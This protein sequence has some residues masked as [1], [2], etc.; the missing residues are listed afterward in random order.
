MR[1]YKSACEFD[2][3]RVQDDY[4]VIGSEFCNFLSTLLTFRLI[5]AFDKAGL[6]EEYTYRK[7][8][9]VLIRAKKARVGSENWQL[10]RRNP[11]HLEILQKLDLIPK[12]EEAP[13]K[14]PGRPRGSKNR[15]KTEAPP[16]DQAEQPVKRKRGRP[17]VYSGRKVHPSRL[18][19]PSATE[20]RP[21]LHGGI[22][23]L[24]WT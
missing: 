12:P 22:A 7:I 21:T 15:P 8:F 20:N 3:T 14:K 16:S 19:S 6:L 2:E 18:I 23:H 13:K 17:L 11:S 24:S 5:D 9:S 1:Y 10:V 4:S